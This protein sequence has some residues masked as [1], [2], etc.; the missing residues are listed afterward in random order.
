M[1][2]GVAA[3]RR[4]QA[5][6]GSLWP[7][8][9]QV[10][11]LQAALLSGAQ[12]ATALEAWKRQSDLRRLDY[13]SLTLLPL[14]YRNLR[15]TG[16]DDTYAA[17]LKGVYQWSWYRNQSLLDAL[18]SAVSAL[19]DAGVDTILLKGA[20]LTLC[21]YRDR[22]VRP[23]GD[24]DLLVRPTA[25]SAAVGVLRA[26]GWT[27]FA[28]PSDAIMRSRHDVCFTDVAGRNLDLHWRAMYGSFGEDVDDA[29]WS[30]AVPVELDGVSTRTLDHADQLLHVVAHGLDVTRN[31]H[32]V[33]DAM[34]ILRHAAGRLD[35]DQL[36]DQAHA[37]R[38]TVVLRRAMDFLVTNLQV[39]LPEEVSET[40]GALRMSR[41]E[42]AEFWFVRQQPGP[43]APWAPLFSVWFRYL[44]HTRATR[45]RPSV[46]GFARFVADVLKYRVGR[47]N[48]MRW[49]TWPAQ[50]LSA[51]IVV[52]AR[53]VR[54]KVWHMRPREDT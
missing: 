41:F 2:D 24:C 10:F 23:A 20:G 29:L 9:T 33:A 17:E 4:R 5:S 21:C 7:T 43:L 53:F 54:S 38:L 45:G 51:S 25:I 27:P 8:P 30:R 34:T 13:G 46:G 47:P 11:L 6:A 18:R 31:I 49:L 32:W 44:R 26:L 42:R 48:V 50:Q 14:L 12:A 28:E 52:S 35:W 37:R 40:L 19:R 22:A 15:R 3:S 39:P 1:G 36:V 16:L